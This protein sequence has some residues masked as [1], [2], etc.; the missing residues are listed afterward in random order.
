MT[1]SLHKLATLLITKYV[2][3]AHC[4]YLRFEVHEKTKTAR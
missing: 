2:H 3:V 4:F 1:I